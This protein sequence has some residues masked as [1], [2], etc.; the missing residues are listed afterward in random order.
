ME[1]PRLQAY[2]SRHTQALFLKDD[3]FYT[4]PQSPFGCV[5]FSSTHS[6]RSCS[7]R[8]TV[9]SEVSAKG[10]SQALS[11]DNFRSTSDRL[12]QRMSGHELEF[13]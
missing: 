6:F 1:T 2:I 8:L 3:F 5:H 9:C 11:F 12:R 10:S 13:T 7:Q 4:L